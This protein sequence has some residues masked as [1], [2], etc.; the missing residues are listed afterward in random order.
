MK[1]LCKAL[2]A[3]FVFPFWVGYGLAC[4]VMGP[5]RAFADSAQ[6]LAILPGILGEY[7]R[8]IFYRWTMARCERDCCVSF[9][10]LFSHSTA[11]IGH[12][13][14]IG[15]YCMIG[16]VTLSDD[17]L[18]ASG[19]SIANGT[20]QH[21]T[22]RLDVPINQQPGEYPR[23]TIGEDTWIGERAVVLADVGAHCVIGAGALVL[24]PI[25]DFAVAVGVP[26]RVVKMRN[27]PNTK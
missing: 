13:V 24:E 1:C 27:E 25:P 4:R 18:L 9:G 11:E 19:V 23:V 10:V 14:Y 3:V 20:N 6:W 7:V 16:D 22:S 12:R 17:V 2:L 8:Q 5:R 21:G 26:A 15:P